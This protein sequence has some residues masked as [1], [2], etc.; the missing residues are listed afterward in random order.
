MSLILLGSL[1][2]SVPEG[3]LV[4]LSRVMRLNISLLPVRLVFKICPSDTGEKMGKTG[5]ED[6]LPTPGTMSAK[7]IKGVYYFTKP[8]I[9]FQTDQS[10]KK[11]T[12]RTCFL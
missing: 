10:L 1:H 8:D 2:L 9:P 12:G 3:A 5:S 7:E 6:R 11:C 4:T